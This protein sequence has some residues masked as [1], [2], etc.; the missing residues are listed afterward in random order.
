MRKV[1][2][3]D[4]AADRI[5]CRPPLSPSVARAL[6]SKQSR[7]R[8]RPMGFRP[9]GSSVPLR[10]SWICCSFYLQRCASPCCVRG[11]RWA[12]AVPLWNSNG[13]VLGKI[14]SPPRASEL[15]ANPPLPSN[16]KLQV[17]QV[18]DASKAFQK[19]FAPSRPSSQRRL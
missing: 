6:A 8:I 11:L 5:P 14:P 7:I 3:L 12:V 15:S 2:S 18:L 9:K 1:G 4:S 16:S 10:L 17:A 13:T 19:P